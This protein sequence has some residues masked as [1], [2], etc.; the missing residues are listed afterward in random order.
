MNIFLRRP[1]LTAALLLCIFS[2]T[3]SGA[4]QELVRLGGNEPLAMKK[5]GEHGKSG[6]VMHALSQEYAAHVAMTRGQPAQP[7]EPANSVLPVINGELVIDAIAE[8]DSKDL[9]KSLNALGL[10]NAAVAGR[11]VS[12]RLPIGAIPKLQS[13]S[14]LRFARPAY[15][16][17]RQVIG[18][19]DAA[20]L[21]DQVRSSRGL[22]GSGIR[23]GI[24]S[25]SFDHAGTQIALAK[26]AGELPQDVQVLSDHSGNDE[27]RA[28]AEIVHD[29]APAAGIAF[30]TAFNGEAGF[31]N[32]IRALKSAGCQVIVDD[33]G[34][35]AEPMF[36]DGIIAQAV[37]EVKNGGV[38]YFS[39]AG[40]DSNNAMVESG[41]FRPVQVGSETYHQFTS[42]LTH[43]YLLPVR[44]GPGWNGFVLQ[45]AQPYASASPLG[46]SSDVDLEVWVSSMAN[47]TVQGGFDYNIG[48]DP[49]EVVWVHNSSAQPINVYL[50]FHL[51]E[52][53]APTTMMK[54]VWFA[55]SSITVDSSVTRTGALYGHPGAKGACAVGAVRYNATPKWLV[56]PPRLEYFSSTGPAP[57][58]FTV[59][60]VW[61]PEWRAKPEFTAP[62]GGNTSFFYPGSDYEPDGWPNF[63]GTS[64]AAPHAAGVA[65]LMLNAAK[66]PPDEVRVILE[67]TAIDMDAPGFDWN[68]G[69]GFI[70]AD[71]AVDNL[72]ARYDLNHDGKIDTNDINVL[73]LAIHAKS[74]NP[75][76]DVN[77]DGKVN[78]ADARWL[79]LR[80][81]TP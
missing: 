24:L 70:Q 21:S 11:V 17:T 44:V 60:G 50:A 30:Y 71:K 73:L 35:Y 18:Q 62:D 55:D 40:N 58:F 7:F 61:A 65:A 59:A 2:L 78:I 48:F 46:A 53:P 19:G 28:M 52:G 56:N 57:I 25:D 45:W 33:V 37:D 16:S 10:K 22:S 43:P 9:L 23:V 68:T 29:I 6:F 8:N 74:S 77:G 20:M 31:A 42:D 14:A 72:F 1:L 4:G 76:Y 27:G 39:A 81:A 69:Y 13:I 3:A 47:L 41:G 64:A 49:T 38:S 80:L 36:A 51:W 79:A 32:G 67:T 75:N 26:A 54:L 63:F 66:I 12:G 34:Y 15:A 5:R